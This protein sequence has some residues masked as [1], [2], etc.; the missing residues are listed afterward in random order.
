[1]TARKIL[2]TLVASAAGLNGAAASAAYDTGL[3]LGAGPGLSY[4]DPESGHSGFGLDDGRSRGGKL[5]LGYDIDEKL[6]IEGYYADLGEAQMSP[7][8]TIDYRDRGVNGTYYFYQP[9]SGREGLS[10][11]ARLGIGWMEN[12]TELNYVREN[13]SHFM[14]GAG[15]EY[16]LGSGFALRAAYEMFDKD[17]HLLTVSLLKRF[18]ERQAP[19]PVKPE[20]APQPLVVEPAPQPA[21]VVK[22]PSDGDGDGIVDAQDA[23]P[24]SAPG[25][26]VDAAGCKLQEV[27]Q[28]KGVTFALNSA[29][30]VG[31]S[32]RLLNDVAATLR[33][34][35]EQRVEVAGYT[36][37]Q[38]AEEYNRKLSER[39]ANAVREYLL[40]Q[41]VAA[42]RLSARGYGEAQPIAD[43]GTAE[44]RAVNR[45]VEL[46][47]LP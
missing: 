19:P 28:L 23:C 5:Y 6:S 20:P 39:R 42:E 11:F 36:D 46:H 27:I 45:R 31:D 12:D 2:I 47:L 24:D 34:Y 10:A 4:L 22:P 15:L 35:P 25:E 33:R 38:G 40:G 43:N 3:Y 9:H 29:E 41:G 37:S 13:D 32:D 26:K 30:L 17:A 7:Y 21:P 1:M 16:G 14:L 44:G 8:G 18:G